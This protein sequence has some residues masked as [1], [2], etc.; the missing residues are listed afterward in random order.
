MHSSALV[1]AVLTSLFATS[2]ATGGLTVTTAQG[3]VT[4]TL[5]DPTV[6][7]WL[8]I[9]FATAGRWEAP[10]APPTRSTTLSANTYGH[11]CYQLT[12]LTTDYYLQFAHQDEPLDEDEDCLTLNIWAPSTDR[13]QNAAVLIWIYGG[14]FQF[15]ATDLKVYDGTNFVKDSDDLIIVTFNYRINIFGQPN[16]PQLV[17]STDSQNFG[18]LDQKAAIEWVKDNI[19]AFGGDASRITIWGQ[20]AGG[21]SADIYAQAYPTDTTV[22]GII[23][24]SGSISSLNDL[25]SPT[26]DSAPWTTVADAVGC[27]TDATAA[28]LLCMKGIPAATLRQAAKDAGIVFF[29]LVTDGTEYI[30]IHS[31]WADR[32]ETGNFLKVPTII[33]TVQ[34][35][36]D[37]LTVG[38]ELAD[39]GNA[40][41]F[42]TTAR[43]DIL[44]QLGGT[45]GASTASAQRVSNGVTTWR[46]Q[47]QAI[48]PGISTRQDLRAFH[49]SDIPIIFGTYSSI[50]S[51]PAPTWIEEDLSNYVKEAWSQFARNPTS[52]LTSYG[53]PVYNPSTDTLVQLGNVENPDGLTLGSPSLLDATCS[54][55]P[56]LLDILADLTTILNSI[57]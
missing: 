52:G 17:S 28:Q 33:G 5:P 38:G 29:K 55:A 43:S 50:Q 56:A 42:I 1:F 26:L 44:S 9:P 32:M 15:G 46:Y 2:S 51:D 16:A 7:Q 20:S 13:P 54:H 18:L 57:P 25:G 4:G 49:G 40:P 11:S 37:P 45:C 24:E 8:G 39:R 14:G 22:K 23:L 6:R 31:D 27:G 35:E 19:A 53:W 34:H 3:D 48:F 30:V 12:T 41:P 47:Y 21:T 10:A 36:A